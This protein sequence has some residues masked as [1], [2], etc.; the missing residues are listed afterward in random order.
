MKFD[1]S[2][3]ILETHTDEEIIAQV[4]GEEYLCLVVSCLWCFGFVGDFR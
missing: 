2:L 3:P 1:T 4:I